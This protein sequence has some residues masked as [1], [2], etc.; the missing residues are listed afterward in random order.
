MFK[1]KKERAHWIFALIYVTFLFNRLVKWD[2]HPHKWVQ[3]I[4]L[5]S[6]V[7]LIGVHISVALNWRRKGD[8]PV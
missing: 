1:T 3:W 7:V 6:I 2:F 5:A 4:L 8:P